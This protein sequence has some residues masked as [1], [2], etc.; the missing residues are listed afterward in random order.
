MKKQANLQSSTATTWSMVLSDYLIDRRQRITQSYDFKPETHHLN[1]H[2]TLTNETMMPIEVEME[3]AEILWFQSI[4]V[5]LSQLLEEG[6]TVLT[7]DTIDDVN[8]HQK[9]DKQ[10]ILKEILNPIFDIIED[11]NEN[12]NDVTI[13]LLERLKNISITNVPLYQRNLLKERLI[14]A[15]KLLQETQNDDFFYH[16]LNKNH[17]AHFISSHDTHDT[18]APIILQR[19]NKSLVFW[20][21]RNWQ[22]ERNIYQQIQRILSGQIQKLPI[23]FNHSLNAQQQQAIDLA[24]TQNFCIITGG[25]GTGK[26]HTIAQFFIA[27]QNMAQKIPDMPMP[28][29]AL[30][31]PTGKAAQRM[32]ESLQKAL[33]MAGIDMVLPQAKTIHRLLKIGQGGIAQYDE[34]QPLSEDIIIIDEASMLGVELASSLFSAIKTNARLILLGDAN[35]LAAV[36]AG[37]V[38]SDLCHI[39]ALQKYHC[40]LTISRRFDDNSGIGQLAKLIN[41]SSSGDNEQSQSVFQQF[42]QICQTHPDIN[43]YQLNLMN[44]NE[45][46]PAE[47]SVDFSQLSQDFG[48]YFERTQQLLSQQINI[49]NISELMEV[50]NQFRILTT[51]HHGKYG[52]I[53]INQLLSNQHQQWLKIPIASHFSWYHG[54]PI[55]VLQN[56]YE[57]GLF[58]GDIGICLQTWQKD[59]RGNRIR[60]DIQVFFETK[61]QGLPISLLNESEVTTAYAMTVHKS[62]GSEFDKVAIILA[63]NHERLLSKEMIYTAVTRAKQQV[64]IYAS[65][66]AFMQAMLTPTVR[67]TGLALHFNSGD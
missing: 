58:N 21:Q 48:R 66:K 19:Y 57:L 15:I 31:A 56:N 12:F 20:L 29:L 35:Q 16:I 25:P 6:H 23:A 24:N 44:A 65:Q 42:L 13:E 38:L 7:V 8:D 60:V 50:F 28:S 32:Q 51:G 22:A 2:N 18:I 64:D 61:E 54:R 49:E 9:I 34:N 11:D 43:F 55:M 40:Q 62:Q 30:A 46:N 52:D 4:F 10:L 53:Y 67:Y 26:T 37:A 27:L 14:L 41:D 47:V 59:E 36:D 33:S 5:V 39:K 63:E 45:K 1:H 3:E 17:K